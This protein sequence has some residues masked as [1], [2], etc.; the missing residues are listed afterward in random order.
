MRRGG[1]WIQRWRVPLGF[2]CA[3]LFLLFA[4]PS[5][6]TLISGAIVSIL[7]L[8]LRAWA[9]GHIRKND[10]LA[11]SGPYAYTRNPLYLGSFL[12]GLGF[13]IGS[14]RLVLGLL[15]GLLFL[16]IYLPVMRVESG[17]MAQ[18]FGESHQH[19]ARV[20]PLFF[21]RLTCYRGSEVQKGFDS[22][23]YMRYREYRAALGLVI[24][25]GLLVF[26]AYY[27]K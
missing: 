8:L 26:K 21:P 18:L 24:A 14:G 16:G 25:W 4:R 23:L 19:Y 3:A 9:S 20:V 22:S 12:L 10:A 13:T 6:R 27:L 15:F 2:L 1:T 17:T 5:A 7:G 11:T